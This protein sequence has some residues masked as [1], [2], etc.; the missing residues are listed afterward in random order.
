VGFWVL[1]GQVEK[2]KRISDAIATPIQWGLILILAWWAG[3]LAVEGLES[4]Q[5]PTLPQVSLSQSSVIPKGDAVILFGAP[6]QIDRTPKPKAEVTSQSVTKTRLNLQLIGLI[7][8][9]DNGVALINR[10]G[11]TLVVGLGERVQTKVT[12]IEIMQDAVVLD[13]RGKHEKLTLKGISK[14]SLVSKQTVKPS[15]S[16]SAN[17]TDSEKNLSSGQRNKLD[18]IGGLLR[19]Q[20]LTI[21]QYIR[22]QPINE[23]GVWTGVKLWSKKDKTL[24]QALGFAEGDILREVNGQ[25]IQK[26]ASNPTL[27]QK[28]LKESSFNLVVERHGALENISVNFNR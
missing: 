10:S 23:G 18:E 6:K 2:L 25:S 11:K 9:G 15:L 3:S 28:F 4:P 14:Q 20:P 13:N 21:S 22:F 19:E 27:W 12:L 26:M 8:Q 17:V 24:Y 7:G 16:K 1:V 5:K